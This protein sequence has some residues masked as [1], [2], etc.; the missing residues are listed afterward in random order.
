VAGQAIDP[1]GPR[2]PGQ[3]HPLGARG[4]QLYEDAT[5]YVNGINAYIASAKQPL[6]ILT[7]MPGKYAAIGQPG[8]PA[9][10]T[11]EDLVSIATLVGGIFGNGGGDQ[12]YNA[13]LYQSML[14]KFGAEHRSVAG[15]PQVIA[16]RK[17]KPKKPKKP[18]KPAA[19][20]SGFATF[21]SFDDPN[22]PEAP[23]TVR[24][25][26]F[27]Y[28]TLPKPSKAVRATIALPDPGSVQ[29]VS[30]IVGGAAP[31]GQAR[32]ARTRA[33]AARA[34]RS[35]LARTSGRGCWVSPAPCPT[36]C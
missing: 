1:A 4:E 17:A 9:P 16:T 33:T 30:T 15:S 36:P 3:Q 23:T 24:G 13:Q 31:S 10:F 20:H 6:N 18:K 12:L 2:Q 29:P 22:D 26:T 35:A 8:G 5:S 21:L 28:Q 19:D 25:K 34:S 11:L 14:Q 7:M 27:N 32:A